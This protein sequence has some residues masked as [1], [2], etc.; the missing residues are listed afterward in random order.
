MWA[1]FVMQGGHAIAAAVIIL[2]AG[3]VEVERLGAAL[4]KAQAQRAAVTCSIVYWTPS[5][6]RP[7]LCCRSGGRACPRAWS[8]ATVDRLRGPGRRPGRAP[9]IR[10]RLAPR[11]GPHPLV[12]TAPGQAI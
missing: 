12:R 10:R 9:P 8:P 4:Q 1:A 2:I 7:Q 6:S 3:D 5:R 11:P